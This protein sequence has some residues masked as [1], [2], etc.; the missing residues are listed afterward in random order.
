MITNMELFE[1]DKALETFTILVDTREQKTER[2]IK[3]LDSMQCPY[4]RKKLDFGDY[5]AKCEYDGKEYSLECSV[6]V[7][8]KMSIDELCSC[9][10]SDRK[11]FV[12]EFERAKVSGAKMYLLIENADIEKMYNGKYRS[13]MTPQ[14]LT[15]S[16]FTFLCRYDSP[17]L[18]AKEE[19][20][21]KL[22]KDILY[23]EMKE[24][25][26][27]GAGMNE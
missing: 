23:R 26:I 4:E 25:L 1:I 8:R 20:S 21:G 17:F 15:A 22:I 13:R 27:R 14:A 11:R 7:E 3:R 2:S 10:C 18:F 16:L 9:M 19:T 24:Y 6:V 5:S 12:K